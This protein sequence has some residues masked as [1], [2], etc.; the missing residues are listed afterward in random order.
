VVY[1]YISGGH[2]RRPAGASHAGLFRAGSLAGYW[3]GKLGHP[4]GIGSVLTGLGLLAAGEAWHFANTQV[5][6]TPILFMTAFLISMT[7]IV[8]AQYLSTKTIK[9][10][11]ERARQESWSV[12]MRK[13]PCARVK[14]N[15]VITLMLRRLGWPGTTRMER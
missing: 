4:A 5:Q 1:L 14:Q 3:W 2:F 10:A 8:A 12:K 15:Y 11:L 9:D 7:L 13:K 6:V